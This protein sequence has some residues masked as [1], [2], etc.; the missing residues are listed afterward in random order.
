MEEE[1]ER[2]PQL[3]KVSR[4]KTEKEIKKEKEIRKEKEKE[5]ER[6]RKREK[7]KE[8]DRKRKKEKERTVR[9]HFRRVVEKVEIFFS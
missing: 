3:G 9:A 7:E 1:S 2:T 8:R 5:K 6:E 4:R